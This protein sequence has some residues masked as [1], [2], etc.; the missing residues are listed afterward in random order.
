MRVAQW[1]V[2]APIFGAAF[3]FLFLMMRAVRTQVHDQRHDMDAMADE[4]TQARVDARAAR[5]ET[6]KCERRFDRLIHW[7]RH[8]HQ[9]DVPQEIID[10]S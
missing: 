9:M 10:P 7:L 2:A 8:E 4:L 6:W 1:V 3:F 5:L